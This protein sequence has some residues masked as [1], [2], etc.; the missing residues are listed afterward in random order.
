M[1]VKLRR[2]LIALSGVA[3]MVVGL[4]GVTEANS[5]IFPFNILLIVVGMI[6]AVTGGLVFG[7]VAVAWVMKQAMQ[8]S[9][10]SYWG[11]SR[12]R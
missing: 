2:P 1:N 9:E 10:S 12:Q 6:G 11:R 7:V 5:F 3:A 8:L 4:V